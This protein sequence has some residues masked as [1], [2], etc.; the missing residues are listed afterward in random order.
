[1][2]KDLF[3]QRVGTGTRSSLTDKKFLEE[4]G[5]TQGTSSSP[6]D[7]ELPRGQGVLKGGDALLKGQKVT[8]WAMTCSTDKDLF[9]DKDLFKGQG[10]TQGTRSNPRDQEYNELPRGQGALKGSDVLLK[11]EVTQLQ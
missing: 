2:N 5:V 7:N 6:R 4:G 3:R 11:G 8:Q 9:R 10:V 1:M